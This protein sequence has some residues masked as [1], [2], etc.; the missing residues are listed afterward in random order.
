MGV[1][2]ERDVL[3]RLTEQVNESPGK[4]N[5]EKVERSGDKRG[6]NIGNHLQVDWENK[7]ML[8]GIEQCQEHNAFGNP[9]P[10]S[11][12]YFCFRQNHDMFE[13]YIK[14]LKSNLSLVIQSQSYEIKNSIKWH[15]PI[16]IFYSVK[17]V[18]VI[19]KCVSL[20]KQ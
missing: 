13:Y 12:S 18:L 9:V 5:G 14:T 1:Q 11:Q 16:Q 19:G 2:K 10:Q 6:N 3:K 15:N 20:A 7:K 8:K 17:I 4:Q